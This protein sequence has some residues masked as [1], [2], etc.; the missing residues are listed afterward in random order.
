MKP[1]I[2]ILL[3][4]LGTPDSFHP[5]DVYRYLIEFLTDPRVIEGPWILRQLLVR[6]II[7]PFRYKKSAQAYQKIWTKEGS[8][9]MVYGKLVKNL[10]QQLMGASFRVELA[11]RY[12]N[13]SIEEG[14]KALIEDGVKQLIVLPLFPHYASAT[15]GSV[16]QHVMEVL[17]RY[18][19][20]PKVTLID[21]FGLHPAFIEA[22]CSI[23]KKYSLD[24][25]DQILFSFH[26][27]P[28]E[29]LL[30]ADRN[31]WCLKNSECCHQ[32]CSWNQRCYAAQCHATANA[33]AKGLNVSSKKYAICF[34]SRLGK[35]P[36]LQP[37]A[38]E[39][40]RQLAEE[41][42][43]RILVFCPSFVCD[44]LE[45]IFEIRMEYAQEFIAAGG[46]ELDL[47]EGLNAE[48]IWIESLKSIIL[49]SL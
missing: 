17:S 26:G 40:I 35:K 7:V 1:S 28:Q 13:P 44:C 49:E 6:G 48:P 43:K 30:K 23:G 18:T 22:F 11:M 9:L 20:I 38:S 24:D 15:T 25:Y 3:I 29:S 4:N 37:Y 31:D 36:W 34:Q 2:G 8:P 45:T 14:I 10:L 46:Y 12:Q 21:E 33:I 47:V 19:V 41:G 39:K 32:I 5:R 27:L 16:H 42:K